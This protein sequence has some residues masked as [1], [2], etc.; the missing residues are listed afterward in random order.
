MISSERISSSSARSMKT[1]VAHYRLEYPVEL[2]EEAKGTY[3]YV[4]KP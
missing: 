4:Q 3:V 2:S 1:K